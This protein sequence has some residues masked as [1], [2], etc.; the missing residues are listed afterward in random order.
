MPELEIKYGELFNK[1]LSNYVSNE[2]KNNKD[3][4]KND[5]NFQKLK[6][7][8]KYSLLKIYGDKCGFIKMI[9]EDSSISSKDKNIIDELFNFLDNKDI[10]EEELRKYNKNN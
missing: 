3:I 6:N 5:E 9:E 2:F 10:N 7:K 8:S 4:I 1:Y